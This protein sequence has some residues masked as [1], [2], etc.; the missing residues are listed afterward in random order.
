ME[1]R[2]VA[3]IPARLQSTRLPRKVLADIAGKPMIRHVYERASLAQSINRVL[4]AT[5]SKEVIRI[6]REWGVAVILTSP[7]LP[8]GTARIASIVNKIDAEI[9]VNIQGDQPL[10]EPELID[11]LVRSFQNNRADIVTPVFR[12]TEV[13]DRIDP[14]LAKVVCGNDGR[15]LYFSRSPIPH[16]RDAPLAEWPKRAALWAQ[17]GIYGFRRHVLEEFDASL[18][19]SQLEQAEKLEQLRFLEAGYSIY[20]IKTRFRQIAVDTAEDLAQVRRILAS[21]PQQESG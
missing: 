20:T 1:K 21:Q 19:P 7:N 11:E 6:V 18:P 9:V 12:I 8:S 5:D 2:A 3:V 13:S 17:Y 4:V 10:V 16:V 15:A 14:G